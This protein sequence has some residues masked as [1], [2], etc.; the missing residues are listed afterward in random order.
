MDEKLKHRLVGA[1]VILALAAFFLPLILDSEKYRTKIV[2]QIPEMP[3]AA[4]SEYA[5]EQVS[6][7]ENSD[8]LTAV[9]ENTDNSSQEFA[10]NSN[11]NRLNT[12]N[13]EQ[14]VLVINLDQDEVPEQA[15][16]Q[17]A[18]DTQKPLNITEQQTVEQNSTTKAQQITAP[19]E[20]SQ[21]DKPKET[22]V[23]VTDTDTKASAVNNTEKVAQE[24]NVQPQADAKVT[25]PNITESKVE[26]QVVST[27]PEFKDQPWLIQIGSFSNKENASK[28]VE[29]LRNQGFR[30]YQRVD[31]KFSRV[32]VGPYPD[33]KA[34]QDRQA[35]LEGIV[36]SK[37]KLVEFDAIAH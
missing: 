33:K 35:S 30:A 34:A 36:G 22:V 16:V 9:V 12:N 6:A 23:A 32:Y 7:Q 37:V 29:N 3:Q 20:S 15:T 11:D 21:Q 8:N 13:A 14:G 18:V 19:V 5:D 25:E 17:T 27:K 2:S 4:S 1:A 26:Q 31:E 24:K 10:D 28:L